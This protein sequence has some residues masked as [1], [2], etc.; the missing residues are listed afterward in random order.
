V[1][2]LGDVPAAVV[3]LPVVVV[4][5][6]DAVAEVGGSAVRPVLFMVDLAVVES[7]L[8]SGEPAAFVFELQGAA[9]REGPDRGFAAEVEDFTVGAEDGGDDPGVAAEHPGGGGADLQ[10]VEQR[11]GDRLELGFELVIREGDDEVGV[12]TRDRSSRAKEPSAVG[13]TWV[14]AATSS[15]STTSRISAG[16]FLTLMMM[17]RACSNGISPASSAPATAGQAGRAFATVMCRFA[18][19]YPR[20]RSSISQAR[21][22][23]PR[24]P[25]VTSR[26]CIACNRDVMTPCTR[27]TALNSASVEVRRVSSGSSWGSCPIS[28]PSV[29]VSVSSGSSM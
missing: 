23:R 8:A 11:V 5:E 10:A 17:L 18:I 26:T 4:A 13:S 25:V 1:F 3:G 22:L 19:S 9:L 15:F 27:S 6:V 12:F 21:V 14:A 7:G 16:V 2:V 20:C 28:T 29:A 24:S